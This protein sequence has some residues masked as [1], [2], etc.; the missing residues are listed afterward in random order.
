MGLVVFG[1]NSNFPLSL[2]AIQDLCLGILRILSPPVVFPR[3]FPFILE[4]PPARPILGLSAPC[5]DEGSAKRF[6]G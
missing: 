2:S 1:L 5:V 6:L 3:M 4:V